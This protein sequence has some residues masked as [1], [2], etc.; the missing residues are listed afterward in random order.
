MYGKAIRQGRGHPG[1]LAVMSLPNDPAQPA[2]DVAALLREGRDRLRGQVDLP[3]LEA[4]LLLA[5]ASGRAATRLIARPEWHPEATMVRHFRE[6]LERRHSGVPVAYLLGRCEFYGLSLRVT[7]DTLIPRPETELLVDTALELGPPGPARVLDLGTGSGAI[8]LSVARSRPDWQV[9]ATDV[10]SAALRVAETN[11]RELGL[12]MSFRG[13][14]GFRPVRHDP[15]FD[16]ILSN[17]P[18]VASGDGHLAEGD[19]AH[20]PREALVAGADGMDFLR[21]LLREAPQHLDRKGLMILEHGHDQAS[22][23]QSRMR[24][25]GWRGVGGRKDLAGHPRI[26]IGYHPDKP[27][28]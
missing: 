20:E 5:E 4:R 2:P 18:Y 3:E 26:A 9:V 17:P 21:R 28:V 27:L 22:V 25:A 12:D 1:K 16:L 15:P 13:G 24:A 8:A 14:D 11:A 19:V 6:L 7:P 10:S 23:L